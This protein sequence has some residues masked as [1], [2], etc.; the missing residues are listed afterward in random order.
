LINLAVVFYMA[1]ALKTGQNTHRI[2]H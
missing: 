1:Y 2:R